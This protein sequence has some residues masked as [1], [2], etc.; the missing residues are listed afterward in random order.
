MDD[1]RLNERSVTI[2]NPDDTRELNRILMEIA[3]LKRNNGA[4]ENQTEVELTRQKS[5]PFVPTHRFNTLHLGLKR[6]GRLHSQA[7]ME[8]RAVSGF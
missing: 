3:N 6:I 4:Q 2:A 1:D 5:P 8:D 7:M